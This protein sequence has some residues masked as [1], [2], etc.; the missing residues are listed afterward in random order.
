MSFE[1]S[2]KLPGLLAPSL[3]YKPFKYPWAYDYWKVQ[4][5]VHWLPEEVPLG[6]DCKDWATKLDEKRAQ[7]LDPDLPILHAVGR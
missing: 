3:T 1:T 6:E 4:Q 7:S 2:A 5:Q